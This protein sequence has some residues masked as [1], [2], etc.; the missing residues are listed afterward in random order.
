ELV[1]IERGPAHYFE[2][3]AIAWIDRHG[4]ASREL[5]HRVLH[6]LLHA[7]VDGED[8]VVPG[9]RTLRWAFGDGGDTPAHGI[10]DHELRAVPPAQGLLE[11]ALD[12]GAPDQIS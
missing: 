6:C 8:R 11:A 4:R 9:L 5:G 1:G 10:H 12:A 2:D 3:A 7:Q